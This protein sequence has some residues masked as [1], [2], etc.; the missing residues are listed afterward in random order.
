MIPSVRVSILPGRVSEIT[1]IRVQVW[2]GNK[3]LDPA[4]DDGDT[5][6]TSALPVHPPCP[7]SPS[8]EKEGFGVRGR[9]DV[10]GIGTLDERRQRTGTGTRRR[11]GSGG[12]G[13]MKSC[14]IGTRLC[15]ARRASH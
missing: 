10:F 8:K 6:A 11:T 2:P 12:T 7:N 3:V 5:E 1:P 15:V 13:T 4:E 14:R 9:K